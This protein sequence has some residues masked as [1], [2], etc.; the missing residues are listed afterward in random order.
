[1]FAFTLPCAGE[2]WFR[3]DNAKVGL[4]RR[5]GAAA[6]T[7]HGEEPKVGARAL[8]GLGRREK[9]RGGQTEMGQPSTGTG[10]RHGAKGHKKGPTAGSGSGRRGFGREGHLTLRRS[11]AA[12]ASPLA[13]ACER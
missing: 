7:L 4:C 10:R 13:A 5:R 2:G 1:M 3:F 11:S 6:E 8:Q 9:G 12:L